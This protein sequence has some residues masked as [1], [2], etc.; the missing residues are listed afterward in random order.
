MGGTVGFLLRVY[1]H[2]HT[3]THTHTQ[4]YSVF[5]C[6]PKASL[7]MEYLPNVK[8]PVMVIDP[9]RDSM[10]P[11]D[12]RAPIEHFLKELKSVT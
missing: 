2:T 11:S 8:Q 5:Q 10:F 4:Y 7:L 12:Q 1:T 3:H 9:L 6:V